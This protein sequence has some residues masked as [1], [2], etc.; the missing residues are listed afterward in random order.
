MTMIPA[1]IPQLSLIL[2]PYLTL[3]KTLTPMLT[4]TLILIRILMPMPM[5]MP[6]LTLTLIPILT[7]TLSSI[8][9]NRANQKIV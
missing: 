3:A 2:I 1:L 4:L 6:I 9:L 5:P 7:P 8:G